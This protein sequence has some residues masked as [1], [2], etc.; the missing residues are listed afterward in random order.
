MQD[1]KNAGP[2]CRAEIALMR[3]I[4]MVFAFFSSARF[5]PSH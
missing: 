3:V 4:F 2:N 5:G 1:L